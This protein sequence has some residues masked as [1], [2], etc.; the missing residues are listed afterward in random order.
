MFDRNLH[1]KITNI[2]LDARRAR[3]AAKQELE[4]EK[5]IQASKAKLAE[6]KLVPGVIQIY[7]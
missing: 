6:T 5:M 7:A 2:V 3:K 4:Y 1:A